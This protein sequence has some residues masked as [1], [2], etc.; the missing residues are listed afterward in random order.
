M[1]KSV[2]FFIGFLLVIAMVCL[3]DVITLKSG[4]KAEC[5]VAG[6]EDGAFTI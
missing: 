6:F 3:G 2:S 4:K 5:C 1:I